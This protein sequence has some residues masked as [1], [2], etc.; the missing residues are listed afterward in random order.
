MAT[1]EGRVGMKRLSKKE[2]ELMDMDN[3]VAIA[4]G[5]KG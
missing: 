4:G 2:K 5:K 3:S 1:V